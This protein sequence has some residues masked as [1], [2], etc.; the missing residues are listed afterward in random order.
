MGAVDLWSFKPG[1]IGTPDEA[2][3][4]ITD[5]VALVKPRFPYVVEK[6][7]ISGHPFAVPG[8]A[9]LS[10]AVS[11]VESIAFLSQKERESDC[12]SLLRDLVDRAILF[13]WLAADP[14]TRVDVWEKQDMRKRIAMDDAVREFGAEVLDPAWRRQLETMVAASAVTKVQPIEQLAPQ[15]DEY[16]REHLRFFREVVNDGKVFEMLYAGVFRYLSGFTHAAPVAIY[17]LVEEAPAHRI[18][19]LEPTTGPQR[20]VSFAPLA[21]ALILFVAGERLGWPRASDVHGV[22]SRHRQG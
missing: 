3:A 15:A 20:A 5:L 4:L 7:N 10:G 13:A 19:V 1:A 9:L 14:A 22:I 16:W 2:R 6:S 11:T 18:V 21:F 12:N 8:A 17:R